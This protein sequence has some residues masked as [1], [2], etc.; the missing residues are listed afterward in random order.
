MDN[1]STEDFVKQIGIQVFIAAMFSY[2]VTNTLNWFSQHLT[3][4][5]YNVSSWSLDFST[6]QKILKVFIPVALIILA[7]VTVFIVF[8]YH[9]WKTQR[10]ITKVYDAF[11]QIFV[12]LPVASFPW[13]VFH[14]SVPFL[15]D[16]HFIMH[17]CFFLVWAVLCGFSFGLYEWKL[18]PLSVEKKC[19]H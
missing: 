13:A 4:T 17:F 3:S 19:A 12:M 14:L 5:M 16:D 9:F 6:M 7:D 11:I 8:M 15:G 18:K 1:N 2:F 10:K